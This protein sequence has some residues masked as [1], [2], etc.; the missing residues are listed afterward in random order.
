M[1]FLSR[2]LASLVAANSATTDFSTG[3]IEI[4]LPHGWAK[5]ESAGDRATFRD[6]TGLYQLTVSVMGYKVG[7]EKQG[8]FERIVQH[9]LNAERT[10]LASDDQIAQDR[11]TRYRS[12]SACEFHGTDK[13]TGRMFAGR[14]MM[15]DGIILTAY[16]EG[17]RKMPQEFAS[18]SGTILPAVNIAPPR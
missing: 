8:D 13:R 4:H 18:T 12:G 15:A 14:M 17:L 2:I 16:L 11:I 5:V 7:A 3:P 9:R 6:P 10:T 1:S